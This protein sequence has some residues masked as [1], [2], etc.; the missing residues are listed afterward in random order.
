MNKTIIRFLLSFV[1]SCPGKR[2]SLLISH[3]L[4]GLASAMPLYGN[5]LI[6]NGDF[7]QELATWK[8]SFPEESE[9]V[10]ERNHEWV[11]VVSN[12]EGEGSVLQFLLSRSTAA[13]EG[14]K[15]VSPLIEIE[16]G[17]EYEFGADILSRGPSA[18][19]ILEG[20]V[21]DTARTARGADQIPGY[22]RIYRAL[23]HP[24]E[25]SG[26][27]WTSHSRVISPPARYQPTHL[28]L[29]VFAYWPEGEIYFNNVFLWKK[30]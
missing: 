28:L 15:A 17:T 6:G 5:N 8:I 18:K 23:I 14:V 24:K 7:S 20:Y 25:V 21:E 11:D 27:E 30:E 10:Y 4:V 12:P 16:A 29:K 22:R 1:D 2:F 9:T 13:S 3:L 26:K 19:I